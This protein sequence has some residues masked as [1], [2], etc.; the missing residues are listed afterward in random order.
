LVVGLTIT[1]AIVFSIPHNWAIGA[2][3]G[4]VRRTASPN[5]AR[6]LAVNPCLFYS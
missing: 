1:V 6:C 2:G 3:S 5:A 4:P